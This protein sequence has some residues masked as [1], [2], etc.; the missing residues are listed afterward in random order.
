[1]FYQHAAKVKG[2]ALPLFLTVLQCVLV[3][4][5]I[6]PNNAGLYCCFCAG[7]FGFSCLAQIGPTDLILM[8]YY[9]W[10]DADNFCFANS[11]LGTTSELHSQR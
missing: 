3:Y 8:T 5:I 2:V 6:P 1:L 10:P 4:Q 7:L 9:A 11:E